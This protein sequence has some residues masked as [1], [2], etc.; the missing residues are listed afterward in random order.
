M[1]VEMYNRFLKGTFDLV[2]EQQDKGFV[3]SGVLIDRGG[4]KSISV[5]DYIPRFCD[6]GYCGSFGLQWYQ[7]KNLQIDSK[8]GRRD[9]YDRLVGNTT[10][11]L[12][13]M[14]GKSVLEC[15]CGPGRF[16]ELFLSSGAYVVSVDMSR[17]VDVNLENNK[18]TRQNLLLLQQDITR[19]PF[20]WEKFDYVF[21]YGVLQHT[22]KPKDTFYG[23]V[24]Y[25][26]KDG[27]IS[28]DIYRK[29]MIPTGWT[30]PKY[31]WR[32]MTR[33]MS[34]ERLL[35]IVTW[36]IP[37]YIDVDSMV[38]RIPGLGIYLTGLIPIPC[39]NYLERGYSRKERIQHAIMDTFDALSPEHDHPASIREVKQWLI[40]HSELTDV[41][42]FYGS[43]GIVAN[44]RK[45]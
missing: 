41:K 34:K 36:Y 40:E 7:F 26:R 37:K 38:R 9:S 8:N 16:T 42:V 21:C 33:K 2:V 23:L 1:H 19:M 22:P 11:D 27:R 5:R 6:E 18:G 15:G 25:V 12:S 14:S 4:G 10:W 13:A 20:F 39:W 31:V 45:K 43:N 17:A 35:R 44:A 28:V 30:S 24:K 3:K 29:R 32:P